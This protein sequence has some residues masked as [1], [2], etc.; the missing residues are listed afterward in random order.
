MH[1]RAATSRGHRIP[2]AREPGHERLA[3]ALGSGPD[4]DQHPVIQELLPSC[5][6]STYA[7]PAARSHLLE[8]PTM[9][10]ESTIRRLPRGYSRPGV[11]GI[12]ALAA[13][14]LTLSACNGGGA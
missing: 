4:G 5:R 12:A 3:A 8:R 9:T 6:H 10:E 7:P 11:V 14:I 13:G 1:L 2:P